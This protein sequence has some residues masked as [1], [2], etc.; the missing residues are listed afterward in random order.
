MTRIGIAGLSCECST[1]S[2]LATREDDFVVS[3]ESFTEG[4]PDKLADRISDAILDHF[5]QRDPCAKVACET[6]VA[7]GLARTSDQVAVLNLV[8]GAGV[9]H[10]VSSSWPPS[11]PLPAVARKIARGTRP[12]ANAARLNSM[13]RIRFVYRA[14]K[15]RPSVPGRGSSL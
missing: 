11:S 4:H 6:F 10:N 7:D 15:I 9:T 2:P 8:P 3:A 12:A 5:L 13:C 14:S 1:F